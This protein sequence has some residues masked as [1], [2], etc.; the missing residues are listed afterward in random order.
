VLTRGR[1]LVI[2]GNFGK[3]FVAPEQGEMYPVAETPPN[4]LA[5]SGRSYMAWSNEHGTTFSRISTESR[6]S[7][8]GQELSETS[9]LLLGAAVLLSLFSLAEGTIPW[10]LKTRR[11]RSKAVTIEIKPCKP[12]KDLV[13]ACAAGEA[14]LWA[15]AGLSA[16]SEFPD[17]VAF[18]TRLLETALVQ[19][20]V[21][22]PRIAKL[23]ALVD[24]GDAEGA[25]ESLVIEMSA[26]RQQLLAEVKEVFARPADESA[27]H[28]TIRGIHF[29]SA[30]TTNYDDLLERL[31]E[32]WS[33]IV[34]NAESDFPVESATQPFLLKLYGDLSLSQ[35]VLLT[36]S[37][38]RAALDHSKIAAVVRRVSEIRTLLFV[39]CSAERLLA[40][41][42]IF[43]L[44][45]KALT[46]HYLL[47][48]ALGEKSKSCAEE[49]TRR[50]GI[51]VLE[52]EAAT[53]SSALPR[54]LSEL[55]QGV[56]QVRSGGKA[57]LVRS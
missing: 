21:P 34:L 22:P 44:P 51:E 13:A 15:G 30:I 39:G 42:T 52:F 3:V 16:Q 6:M 26:H 45:R 4:S 41:L 17:R 18:V 5:A 27:A 23:Q 32:P 40:D 11:G 9:R 14:V 1:D 8:H 48:D 33:G 49:L 57:D 46:R 24:Q 37:E 38:L 50:F 19:S 31:G 2:T 10:I 35:T 54:F 12:P 53:M 36:R 47:I 43:E 56:E 25:M 28:D 7:L 55:A 29:A 20:S